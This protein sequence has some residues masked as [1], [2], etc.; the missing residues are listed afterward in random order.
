TDLTLVPASLDPRRGRPPAAGADVLAVPLGAFGPVHALLL[1]A[2]VDDGG[3]RDHSREH[4][5]NR[6]DAEEGEPPRCSTLGSSDVGGPGSSS[7]AGASVHHL[8]LR[9]RRSLESTARTARD[10]ASSCRSRA[11]D[12]AAAP[13]GWLRS[14]SPR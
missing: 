2:V 13:S 12:H 9:V 8:D 10:P 14:G 7:A 1:V 4:K 3:E 5:G 6:R 11:A